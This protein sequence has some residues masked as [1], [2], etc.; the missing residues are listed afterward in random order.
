M[1]RTLY[2][3]KKLPK[4]LTADQAVELI[5]KSTGQLLPSK[6][7]K[8]VRDLIGKKKLVLKKDG[9]DVYRYQHDN[10]VDS[11]FQI[12][13]DDDFEGYFYVKH[14]SLYLLDP[15]DPDNNLI[16]EFSFS[17]SGWKIDA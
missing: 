11:P 15:A 3:A 16:K 12:I 8:L 1:V 17:N 14:I 9:E 7:E 6:I 5:I 10:S 4:T 13:L 2:T